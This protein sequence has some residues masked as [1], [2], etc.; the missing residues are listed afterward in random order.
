MTAKQPSPKT[1]NQRFK[2]LAIVVG[3]GAAAP[4][5][6]MMGSAINGSISDDQVTTAPATQALNA[7][8]SNTAAVNVNTSA[9]TSAS[10]MAATNTAVNQGIKYETYPQTPLLNPDLPVIHTSHRSDHIK[11]NILNPFPV[12]NS[13]EDRR[14][15]VYNVSDNWLPVGT[16][17]TY[18]QTTGT[19]PLKQ[20]TSRS[21]TISVSVNGSQTETTSV[22]FGGN[23]GVSKN[24]VSAGGQTGIAYSLARTIGGQASYSLSWNVGQEIGPYQIPAGYTGEATY[25]FRA[26]NM[27]GTQQFCKANGTW[28]TPTAWRAFVPLKNEVHVKLYA[29]QVD[30]A[31][32][33]QTPDWNYVAPMPKPA[34]GVDMTQPNQALAADLQPYLT[35]SSAKA[36]G[37]AGATA[38]H[39]KNVGTERYYGEFPVVSFLVEVK[40]A[41]GP[42]GV[43]RVITPHWFHGAYVQDLGFNRETSTR[44]FLVTLSNPIEKGEEVMVASFN[45]NDGLTKLGRLQ[46]YITVSQIG[47]MAGDTSYYNDTLVDSRTTTLDDFGNKIQGLF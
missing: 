25:G 16:I 39:V 14:T 28:S 34:T 40:T 15:V 27:N 7:T 29:N 4:V 3:I 5:F 35:V 6:A 41:N 12:C 31:T 38:L 24:G 33:E 10:T 32:A 19:I 17:S 11:P 9:A 26:V 20:T 46:N 45:F 2:K 47:R 44:A 1:G 36:V 13:G 18:N 21:Q 8:G 37:F 22:N 43:D 23:G 42:Q 30:A